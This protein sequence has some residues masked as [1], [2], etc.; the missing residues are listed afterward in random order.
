MLDNILLTKK[1]ADKKNVKLLK[2]NDLLKKKKSPKAVYAEV[3]SAVIWL[4]TTHKAHV[5]RLPF[6]L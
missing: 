1:R 5:L 6:T 3:K 4:K 2:K